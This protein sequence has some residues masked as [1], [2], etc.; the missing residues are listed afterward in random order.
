MFSSQGNEYKVADIWE[1]RDGNYITLTNRRTDLP[2]WFELHPLEVSGSLVSW[3]KKRLDEG[4][5]PQEPVDQ[6]NVWRVFSG[7]RIAWVGPSREGAHSEDGVLGLVDFKE[8][9]VVY[10]DP[11]D[12]FS[13]FPSF[14]GF[15]QAAPSHEGARLCSV[16]WNVLNGLGPPRT[17]S[18]DDQWRIG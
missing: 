16:G 11:F 4:Y 1:L 2:E 13:G 12:S 14:G 17:A 5:K 15:D 8:N 7:D 3:M 18:T 10:G 6:K 9:A